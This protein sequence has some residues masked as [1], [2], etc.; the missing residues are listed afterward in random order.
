MKALLRDLRRA[1]LFSLP[2]LAPLA[3]VGLTLGDQ[4]AAQWFPLVRQEHPGLTLAMELLSDWGNALFYPLYAAL[5]WQGLR[6]RDARLVRLAL[7]YLGIQLLV[8]F[9]CVRLLKIAIGRPRPDVGGLYQ[10]LAL[11]SGH[12]SLPSG[13]TSEIYGASLPLGLLARP[14]VGLLFSLLAA[15]VAFSRIYLSWHHPSDVF[16]GWLL[17]TLAGLA[18]LALGPG[19]A[20][21]PGR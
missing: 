8:S 10:P 16:F 20:R 11:D 7:A 4:G 9:L 12:N 3:V 2:L 15:A 18:M 6:R 5:L 1:L 14:A 17:G 13:H 19:E 21:K